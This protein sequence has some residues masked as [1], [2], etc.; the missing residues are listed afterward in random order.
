MSVAAAETG[1][2][3]NAAATAAN[4]EKRAGAAGAAA[5]EAARKPRGR[6]IKHDINFLGVRK[7][8]LSISAALVVLALV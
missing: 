8:L 6:F 4:A 3:M 2:E 7:V 5:A 1:E